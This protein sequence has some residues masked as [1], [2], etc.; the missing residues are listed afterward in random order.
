[1]VTMEKVALSFLTLLTSITS[2][3]LAS[4]LRN[5]EDHAGTYESLVPRDAMSSITKMA[6]IGDSY[7]AGIGAGDRLGSV[8]SMEA[9]GGK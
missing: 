8:T 7:S 5:V 3:A 6:A 9:G 1:M 2:H 4:P